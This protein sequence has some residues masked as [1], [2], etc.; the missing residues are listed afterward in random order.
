[1]SS[2]FDT[3]TGAVEAA[4]LHRPV[5]VLDEPRLTAN[6]QYLKAHLPAG[7]CLRLADKSLPVPGLLKRGFDAFGTNRVMSF[8]LPLTEKVLAEFPGTEALMGKPM[9]VAAAARFVKTCP[10]A[11][12]VTW[13]ID[14]AERFAAYRGLAE[15]TGTSL[16]VAFEID[17]G[18]GRGG[19]QNP[20][21][22]ARCAQDPGPLTICGVMGYEAHIH[23]LP[24]F[25]GGGA[26]AQAAATDRLR[27]FR[28]SLGPEQREIVNTGGSTTVLGLPADSPANDLTI[29]SLLVKP[30]DFDQ[31]HNDPIRPAL[32]IVTPVLKTCAHG[33]PGNP[34]LSRFLRRTHM[35]RDR[36]SFTYGGKWMAKP[37]HPAGMAESPFYHASSNQQGLCPPRGSAAPRHMVF[38]PTQ[39]E[40][41]L[42]HFPSI[43][44]FDGQNLTG[45][46]APFQI[47]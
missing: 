8:H 27:A 43:E 29:G 37:V 21:E 42:Q 30:S 36:I 18:L 10:D 23:A 41:V 14:S 35:I 20:H 39:S 7:M 15:D 26:R 12:Q 17:I 4:G 9:P 38:R 2:Y 5:L 13:L 45:R 24:K 33:L 28:D 11:A 44:L 19:F 40:A 3:L 1:M 16:R 6:L 46:L 22:T 34:G 32:F 31:L 47:C 25:L